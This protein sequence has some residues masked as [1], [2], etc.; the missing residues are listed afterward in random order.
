ME[1]G[2]KR[3]KEENLLRDDGGRDDDGEKEDDDG[4]LPRQIAG[5]ISRRGAETQR[6][7][8]AGTAPGPPDVV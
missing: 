3:E 1:T 7:D 6:C 8:L 5:L 4:L 2:E